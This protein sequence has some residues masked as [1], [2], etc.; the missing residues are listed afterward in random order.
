MENNS[1]S[2][3]H[4]GIEKIPC[5]GWR[6][7]LSLV[8]SYAEHFSYRGNV[9]EKSRNYASFRLEC[10]RALRKHIY[11]ISEVGVRT[12]MIEILQQFITHPNGCT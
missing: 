1:K 8:K 12:P 9:S 4:N 6:S 7:I 10:R 2:D 3:K 11:A 5:G